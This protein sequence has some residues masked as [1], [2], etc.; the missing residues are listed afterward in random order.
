V[1]GANAFSNFT[2]D[3]PGLRAQL[4]EHLLPARPG[5]GWGA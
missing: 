5:G 1:R 2:V 4:R 3:V